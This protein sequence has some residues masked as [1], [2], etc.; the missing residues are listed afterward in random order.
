MS[1]TLFQNIC[2]LYWPKVVLMLLSFIVCILNSEK[3]KH[4]VRCKWK[5]TC[6]LF[7]IQIYGPPP[8][9]SLSNFLANEGG[10]H[11]SRLK[12]LFSEWICVTRWPWDHE[13]LLPSEHT[14]LITHF[15][16]MLY[17][18]YG[19]IKFSNIMERED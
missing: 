10:V 4:L 7:S 16:T 6:D 18:L 1:M 13:Y 12:S 5:Q 2:D 9:F 14:C 17:F 15:T 3:F 8:R 19:E 11:E